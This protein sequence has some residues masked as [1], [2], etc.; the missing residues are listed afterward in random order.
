MKSEELVVVSS[1]SIDG[2]WA[3][4]E[5]AFLSDPHDVYEI[6]HARGSELIKFEILSVNKLAMVLC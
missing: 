1:Y 3:I 4:I 6:Q 2:S 5:N